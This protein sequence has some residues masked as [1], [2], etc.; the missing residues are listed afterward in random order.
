MTWNCWQWSN[1]VIIL[2]GESIP[3]P[4]K[5]KENEW[6]LI[7]GYYRL[8]RRNAQ[9]INV[10]IKF[11]KQSEDENRHSGKLLWFEQRVG[12]VFLC[13]AGYIT[14]PLRKTLDGHCF[15]VGNW[16][17]REMS[18]RELSSP[19]A[20]SLIDSPLTDSSLIEHQ[21]R[22]NHFLNQIFFPKMR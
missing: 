7:N 3:F 16:P 4:R 6:C 18:V 8:Q 13:C 19:L 2:T 1:E 12:C 15:M 21:S 10:K 14:F 5:V 22:T 9:L 20:N 11:K 17:V